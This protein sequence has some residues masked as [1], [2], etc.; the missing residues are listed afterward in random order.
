VENQIEYFGKVG[1]SVLG[2]MVMSS[3]SPAPTTG[4]AP[5]NQNGIGRAT[6]VSGDTSRG[7]PVSASSVDQGVAQSAECSDDTLVTEVTTD[8]TDQNESEQPHGDHVGVS[9]HFVDMIVSN[10][11][12]DM[13]QVSRSN[14]DAQLFIIL[15]TMCTDYILYRGVDHL[16]SRGISTS[17]SSCMSVGQRLRV[18]QW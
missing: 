16:S 2:A 7:S 12:Q 9:L 3:T 15:S 10:G 5:P 6:R 14:P 1:M 8:R 4:S 18:F 11:A 13:F 17:Y